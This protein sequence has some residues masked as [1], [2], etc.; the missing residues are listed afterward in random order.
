MVLAVLMVLS[1]VLGSI[2]CGGGGE[3]NA[4]VVKVGAVLPMSGYLGQIGTETA[5]GMKWVVD[6]INAA[7]GIEE[8][9]GAQ[10]KLVAVDDQ[11]DATI[12]ASEVERLITEE[13]VAAVFVGS[14]EVSQAQAAPLADKYQVPI[15]AS[16]SYDSAVTAEGYGYFW[17]GTSSSSY[18]QMAEAFKRFIDRLFSDYG[19]TPKTVGLLSYQASDML[20]GKTQI[21]EPA[22]AAHNLTV[23]F[24]ETHTFGVS[25]W[26]SYALKL[27]QANPDVFLSFTDPYSQA[28]LLKA[29]DRLNYLPPVGL[30]L[31]LNMQGNI[32]Q[33]GQDVADR[34]LGQPGQFTTAT[35]VAAMDYAPTRDFVAAYEAVNGAGSAGRAI[36]GAQAIR[37]LLTAIKDAKSADP[38]AINDALAEINIPAGTADLIMPNFAPAFKFSDTHEPVDQGYFIVQWQDGVCSVVRPEAYAN[39]DAKFKS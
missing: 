15:L 2:G 25:S 8:L 10:L 38:V 17:S 23:V 12:T 33:I 36:V 30:W 22:L 21:I 5:A 1:L 37:L 6:E 24:N 14:D 13:G 9:G 32:E 28:D 18:P 39:A 29:L 34:T 19:K 31:G 20:K 27:S 4:E 35:V 16:G 3:S 11:G 26:D 7:G